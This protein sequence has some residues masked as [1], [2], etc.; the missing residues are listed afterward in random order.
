MDHQHTLLKRASTYPRPRGIDLSPPD[1]IYDFGLGAWIVGSTG[2]LFVETPGHQNP[3]TKK[4]DV[5]TG[6]DQKGA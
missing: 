4:Q 3:R 2:Q 6:E 1:C 5:E